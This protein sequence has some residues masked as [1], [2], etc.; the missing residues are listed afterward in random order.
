MLYI[1]CIKTEIYQIGQYHH[2]VCLQIIFEKYS[3]ILCSREQN[4]IFVEETKY[5]QYRCEFI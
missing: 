1:L 2:I 5:T 4:A 3:L